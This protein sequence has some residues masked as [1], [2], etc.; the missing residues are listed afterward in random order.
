[1]RPEENDGV[2]VRGEQSMYSSVWCLLPVVLNA[3]PI[4]TQK[5]LL[6]GEKNRL[7]TAVAPIA[8][9]YACTF[10]SLCVGGAR[11]SV[12]VRVCVCVYLR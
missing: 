2:R 1:M 12:C 5:G 8:Y 6:I 4:H 11:A 10:V 3:V 7:C 9:P